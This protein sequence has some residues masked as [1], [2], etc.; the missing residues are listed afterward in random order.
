MARSFRQIDLA[1]SDWPL[2]KKFDEPVSGNLETVH[3]DPTLEFV[4]ISYVW[5]ALNNTTDITINGKTFKAT[6]NLEASMRNFREYGTLRRESFRGV[7]LL[8]PD[9]Y[10]LSKLVRMALQCERPNLGL[11]LLQS[12]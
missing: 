1:T 10:K 4:A 8:S 6:K 12:V 5:R 11:G 2:P 9:I 7:T 3:L